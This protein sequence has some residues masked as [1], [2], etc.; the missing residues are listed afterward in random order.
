M[1]VFTPFTV[2]I[3]LLAS[4]V[5]GSPAPSPSSIEIVPH[6]FNNTTAFTK[7]IPT[8]D[9]TIRDPVYIT[10]D[11]M[12]VGK[13]NGDILRCLYNEPSVCEM[14]YSYTSSTPVTAM[15]VHGEYLYVSLLSGGMLRCNLH[16]K[17]SCTSFNNDNQINSLV[18]SGGYIHAGM[19]DGRM[20]RCELHL[21]HSCRMFNNFNSAVTA[22]AA[23]EKYIY[24]A[25]ASKAIWRCSI[26]SENSCRLFESGSA[27][28]S[29]LQ[30]LTATKKYVIGVTRGGTLFN[31]S[32]HGDH[33]TPKLVPNSGYTDMAVFRGSLY[34]VESHNLRKCEWGSF[35]CSEYDIHQDAYSIVFA[36]K[37]YK[38]QERFANEGKTCLSNSRCPPFMTYYKVNERPI[39]EVTVEDGRLYNSQGVLVDTREADVGQSGR[40]AI[41]AMG[42][43]G[44]ILLSNV[45]NTVLQTSSL[46]AGAPVAAAGEMV[47]EEGVI[48]SI[49]ACSDQY[50]PD[51]DLNDQVLE[52]LNWKGYTDRVESF[53]CYRYEDGQINVEENTV[54]DQ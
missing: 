51:V 50:R 42:A 29:E 28:G 37:T 8:K 54:G 48:K 24:A 3:V 20:L 27:F 30:G 38:M 14:F 53:P 46:F 23:I 36:Y 4:A 18:I 15:A 31:C 32:S 47:V 33:C 12:F 19:N 17:N 35:N 44:Q 25:L 40:A 6:K 52:V 9:I 34:T 5:I 45:H 21:P 43:D 39:L 49:R 22:L 2:F 41:F 11:V 16:E 13:S 10:P 26:S 7:I 1:G